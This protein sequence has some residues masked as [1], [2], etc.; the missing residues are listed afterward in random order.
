MNAFD[1][2][3]NQSSTVD[4]PGAHAW[5]TSHLISQPMCPNH[6]E[7]PPIGLWQLLHTQSPYFHPGH[8]VDEYMNQDA[9]IVGGIE[10][11]PIGGS[12]PGS[13]TTCADLQGSEY[14]RGFWHPPLPKSPENQQQ[15][16]PA[17]PV[18]LAGSVFGAHLYHNQRLP[19]TSCGADQQHP[20]VLFSK[21]HEASCD[22]PIP[23][24]S[25]NHHDFTF[26]H[27]ASTG[28]AIDHEFDL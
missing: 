21:P 24:D 2:G 22:D 23:L 7:S 6:P 19:Y 5:G 27:I 20:T 10:Q 8:S 28:A 16:F 4:H 14:T 1:Q 15:N 12:P 25:E 13:D 18:T 9:G 26:H 3:R 11:E 17:V